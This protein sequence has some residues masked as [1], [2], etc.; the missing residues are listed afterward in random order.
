MQ[1]RHHKPLNMCQFG[2]YEPNNLWQIAL[3]QTLASVFYEPIFV[4]H[5]LPVC[6]DQWQPAVLP[7]QFLLH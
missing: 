5:R 2:L 4:H 7:L 1:S 6:E 3:V